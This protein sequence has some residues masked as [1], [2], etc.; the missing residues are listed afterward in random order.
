MYVIVK[1]GVWGYSGD[2]AELRVGITKGVY[3]RKMKKIERLDILFFCIVILLIF[4]YCKIGIWNG[5]TITLFLILIGTASGSTLLRNQ[6]YAFL[7]LLL[8]IGLNTFFMIEIGNGNIFLTLPLFNCF[9]NIATYIGIYCF[10]WAVTGRWKSVAEIYLIVCAILGIS[11]YYVYE[12]RAVPLMFSYIF[13]IPTALNV[14]GNYRFH[15]TENIVAISFQLI[16]GILVIIRNNGLLRNFK[17]R[18]KSRIGLSLGV[19]LFMWVCYG[20]DTIPIQTSD[21]DLQL[22]YHRNGFMVQTIK[23]LADSKIKKPDN[24]SKESVEVLEKSI[25]DSAPKCPITQSEKLPDIIFIVNESFYDLRQLVDFSTDVP[26][27]PFFDNLDNSVKG[28]AVNPNFTTANSEFELLCSTSLKTVWGIIPFNSLRLEEVNSFARTMGE[29]GYVT[30]AFHPAPKGNYNRINAYRDLGFQNLYFIDD[31]ENT[32]EILRW[33]VSDKS[34]Y[35]QVIDIYEKNEGGTPQMIY[36]LT[37]QNHADYEIGGIDYTVNVTKGI[38]NNNKIR[39]YLTIMQESDRA[40]KFIIDYFSEVE[41]PVVLCM[42]GDHPP[43]MFSDYAENKE[44]Q[45]KL[46]G[47]PFVLWA[48]YPIEETELGYFGMTNVS[49][50]IKKYAGIPLTPYEEYLEKVFDKLPLVGVN[51]YIDNNGVMYDYYE[52]NEKYEDILNDYFAIQYKNIKEGDS[53]IYHYKE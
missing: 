36:C 14:I 43:T 2:E 53:G 7:L 23:S 10:F 50:I 31:I 4:L 34:A 42:V 19:I 3:K 5:Y 30:S 13:A 28:Y 44:E 1:V 38:E 29:L 35:E 24:Y 22:A 11:A 15:I 51:Y 52:H 20:I 6:K 39:E 25:Y 9:L 16:L 33:Y 37:I 47:T 40:L 32:P 21:W 49:Q 12:F 45:I 41:R 26:V 27:L 46:M 18:K 8:F 48:N 17:M